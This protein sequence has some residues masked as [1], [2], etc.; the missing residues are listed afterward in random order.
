MIERLTSPYPSAL[1]QAFLR[2]VDNIRSEAVLKQIEQ[3][4]L[5]GDG[6]KLGRILE[7]SDSETAILGEQVQRAFS[8]GAEFESAKV[9]VATFKF[10]GINPRAV[11]AVARTAAQL[12]TRINEGQR[13]AVVEVMRQGMIANQNPRQVALDIVGRVNA[14]TGRRSG[15][16]IGLNGPQIRASYDMRR[17][18]KE[19][20]LTAYKAKG[21]RDKRFD[22]MVEKAV[23]AGKPLPVEKQIQIVARYRSK[24]LKLRGD[25]IGREAI[26]HLNAGRQEAIEQVIDRGLAAE[27]DVDFIWNSSGGPR[28]RDTHAAMDG[29]KRKRDEVFV[30]PSGARLKAPHDTTHGAGPEETINCRCWMETRIDFIAARLRARRE[31]ERL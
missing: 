20:D 14:A 2:A 8:A 5:D 31:A 7:F 6:A 27:Q 19:G 24:L 3:A 16:L 11:N 15:G 23:A 30:S 4:I 25:T 10:N 21:L 13:D 9:P 22:R 17:A 26:G 28:T 29:Q 18:L 1:A 12:V